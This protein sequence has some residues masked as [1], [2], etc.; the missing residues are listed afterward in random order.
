MTSASQESA[1][2]YDV[3]I[4][5]LH[6]DLEHAHDLADR[7]EGLHVFVYDRYSEELLGGDGMVRFGRIFSREACLAV[8]LY[9]AGWGNTDWTSFEE[10][11]ISGRAFKNR[12]RTFFIVRLDNVPLPDWVP[13]THIY[14][15]EAKDSREAQAVAIR[16]RAA[17]LGAVRRE[18]TVAEKL[19]AEA[20][21]GERAHARRDRM[22]SAR[23]RDEILDA[24]KRLYSEIL[25]LVEDLNAGGSSLQL[26]AGQYELLCAVSDPVASL[27]LRVM[28]TVGV[29]RELLLRV[30]WC[31]GSHEIP[32]SR[33]P[34]LRGLRFVGAEHYSASLAEDDDAFLWVHE[35]TAD[36]DDLGPTPPRGASFRTRQ[37]AEKLLERLVWRILHG[38]R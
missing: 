35:P 18:V 4:S 31:Q 33:V 15:T 17:E 16:F 1:Y 36:E 5:F 27:S 6:Q 8:I 21:R 14:A 32:S 26:R 3:A 23:W 2:K 34:E 24:A 25:V 11:H 13:E 12:M 30:N 19:L 9:R 22:Y 38:W 20:R 10:T 29:P 7:L 37:L 28:A